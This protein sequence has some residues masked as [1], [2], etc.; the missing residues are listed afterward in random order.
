MRICDIVFRFVYKP[1][2]F[3]S[4]LLNLLIHFA[5]IDD[6]LLLF[7]RMHNMIIGRSISVGFLLRQ[8]NSDFATYF[9]FAIS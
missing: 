4:V 8:S 2:Y 1:M 5:F 3:A 6:D 7:S 9:L